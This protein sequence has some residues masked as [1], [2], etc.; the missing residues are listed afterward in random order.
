MGFRRNGIIWILAVV[1]CAVV[2]S[3]STKKNT[4]ATR[5]YQAFITRYNVYFNGNEHYKETIKE[6]ERNYADDFTSTVYVH[7][8]EAK[9]NEGA[10][11]P[12]GDFNRSIEKAQ[13]AIQLRSIN[14]KPAKKQGKGNDPGY[15]AWMK[16]EEYN[17]FL[18]NAW[19]LMGR[20]QYM[21]GDF[22]GAGATFMYITKHFSWLPNTVLEA[23]LWQARC[24]I[25]QDWLF[26]AENILRRVKTDQLVNNTLKEQYYLAYASL[27]TKEHKYAEA[28]PMVEKAR[29]YASRAQKIRLGFLQGQL[30]QLTGDNKRA[31]EAFSGVSKN[32]TA[33]YR[34][35]L[36]ARIK[37]SEVYS[38]TDIE[39]EVKAL[40]RMAKLGRNTEYLD[41][42]YYAIGNLYMSRRDTVHAIE[43]YKTAIEKSTR[44][45]VEKGIA[46]LTLGEL[47]FDRHQY[48]LAQ[49][50]Y[51]EAATILPADYP[52]MDNITRR[53]QVLEEMSVYSEGVQLQDSLLKLAAMTPEQQAKVIDKIIE[54]LKKKEKEEEEA[55]RREEYMASQAAAGT[56]LKNNQNAQAPSTF[57]QNNDKSWYFYNTATRNAGKTEFQKR[58]GS[59][60]L[61]DDWRRR[62]KSS[63]SF[64]D[65]D[66]SSESAG[67]EGEQDE[68]A[69][70][71][72]SEGELSEEQKMA[73]ERESDPHFPEYYLKQIPKDS[74]EMATSHEIIQDGLFNLGLLLKDR[75][76][77]AGAAT[78]EFNRLLERYPDNIYRLEVYYNLYMMAMRKGDM[79][80]A[81][82]W[83]RII[84]EEFPESPEG[85][86]MSDPAYFDNLKKMA[87]VEEDI[88][89]KAYN[90]YLANRN[91][92]V[93]K[94]VELME[95]TYPMSNIMPKFLFIDALA[96]VTENNPERFKERLRSMLE[97]YPET[98]ATPMASAWLT[99]LARGRQ[100][101]SGGENMRGMVWNTRL[102]NDSIKAEDVE[103]VL[104][105]DMSPEQPMQLVLLFPVDSV[106]ANQLL[107][108][109]ARHNFGT[110]VTRDFDLEMMNFGNL[111]MLIVKGFANQRELDH[112]R[113]KLNE[114]TGFVLPEQVMPV[115]ISVKNFETLLK[116]GASFDQY[117][118]ALANPTVELEDGAESENTPSDEEPPA[119]SETTAEAGDDNNENRE[120]DE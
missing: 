50:C 85:V 53:S 111:G 30:Y 118:Q 103:K 49:P 108:E 86:A 59:R 93:H 60:K 62:N 31:Y 106:P 58:W 6:M 2:S 110:F 94:S 13:K 70:M 84:T 117:F 63:F 64:N 89:A 57:M 23:Q 22:L 88:Y 112:Y 101:H 7:P 119:S 27:Y 47:Y 12:S 120:Q 26:E 34:T 4:P 9:G 5:K 56:G 77:D 48:N 102:T 45:G 115:M 97:R 109:V 80:Q 46:D 10:P 98:D 54:E 92:E 73:M 55:A 20:S 25:A 74:A 3:C 36:N 91:S 67:D 19:M 105:F 72:G 24:Y 21:N 16:R 32:A 78:S 87:T 95:N 35:Q 40:K 38:G 76:D 41:Q 81:E 28:L 29:G 39:P 99:A 104:E 100:L 42:I 8:A 11:Q 66:T 15:K 116:A 1:L 79:A 52:D 44:N 65:F 61:E 114:N 113:R 51:T 18:H 33:S 96:Y 90:A 69:M 37:Q 68:D 107:Y 43:N 17:P 75:L 83:R 82:R 71:P 14:K